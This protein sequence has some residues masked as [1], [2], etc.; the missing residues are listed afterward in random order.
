[1]RRPG[2]G[3]TRKMEQIIFPVRPVRP[4]DGEVRE[5]PARYGEQLR[6]R[7]S[8]ELV[9]AAPGP[10]VDLP[11]DVGAVQAGARAPAE[12]GLGPLAH[13]DPQPVEQGR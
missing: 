7:V 12:Q 5:S 4:A 13:P 6:H 11:G 10:E 2:R 1:M 9:E 3:A 8:A